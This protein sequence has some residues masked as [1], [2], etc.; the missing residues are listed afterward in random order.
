MLDQ[1]K[2]AAWTQT[3]CTKALDGT[4]NGLDNSMHYNPKNEAV[5]RQVCSTASNAYIDCSL[6]PFSRN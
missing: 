2:N 5:F 1:D 6:K 3:I 4:C